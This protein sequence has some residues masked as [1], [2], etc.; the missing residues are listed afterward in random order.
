[1]VKYN[2]EALNHRE[3]KKTGC[4][5]LSKTEIFLKTKHKLEYI[6]EIRIT[7][8]CLN[9]VIE[10][11]YEEQEQKQ[12]K[13]KEKTVYA[14]IDLGINNLATLTFSNGVQP[15]IYSGKRLKSIN[16]R[17][18]KYKS[19]LQSLLPKG[20]KTSKQI[21]RISDKRTNRINDYLHKTSRMLVDQIVSEG[22]G[23][24]IVGKNKGWKQ[25]INI[26]KVNNQNFVSIPHCKLL[27]K[28]KYKCEEYGIVYKEIEESYSSK[29]SFLDDEKVCKHENY[30]GKRIERGLFKSANG[31]LINSDVN[32]SYNIMVKYLEKQIENKEKVFENVEENFEWIYSIKGENVSQSFLKKEYGIGAFVVSPLVKKPC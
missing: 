26:G 2:Y 20:I 21:K 17:Y 6:K 19:E 16:H 25:E 8:Q 12:Y 4:Y 27:E 22:V 31:R 13:P 14:S 11:V 10:V 7:K 23:V 24:L 30:K 28:I 29:C 5:K 9:Y 3:F 32:G 18:N 15:V 1:M